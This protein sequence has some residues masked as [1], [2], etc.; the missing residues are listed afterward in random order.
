M[1][2]YTAWMP[3]RKE[4]RRGRPNP[5]RRNF[6]GEMRQVSRFQ[7]NLPSLDDVKRFCNLA[8]QHGCEIDVCSGRY[9]VNAKSIMG[10]F[11]IDRDQPATVE[12]YGS[13]TQCADF[14]RELGPLVISEV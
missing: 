12:F 14:R 2:Y 13:D 11:S 8:N 5:R 9:V 7:I 6:N 4:K 1:L 3:Q 10:L